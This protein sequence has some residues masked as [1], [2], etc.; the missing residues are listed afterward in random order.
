MAPTNDLT[1]QPTFLRIRFGNFF[2]F[3]TTTAKLKNYNIRVDCEG[4]TFYGEVEFIRLKRMEKI[5]NLSKKS[6]FQIQFGKLI[7][8]STAYK[9]LL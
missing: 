4:T 6:I 5:K 1:G 8:S 9:Y 2:F 7:F 3:V